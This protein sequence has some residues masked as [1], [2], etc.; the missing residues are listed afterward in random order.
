MRSVRDDARSLGSLASQSLTL[1]DT[2]PKLVD[3]DQI[4]QPG[5]AGDNQRCQRDDT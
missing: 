4:G 5:Q 1:R 3:A 2:R